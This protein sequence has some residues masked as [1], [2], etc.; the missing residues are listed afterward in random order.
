MLRGRSSVAR[1]M[2]RICSGAGVQVVAQVPLDGPVPPPTKDVTP[3]LPLC[4]L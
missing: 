2:R 3:T 4:A 1:S